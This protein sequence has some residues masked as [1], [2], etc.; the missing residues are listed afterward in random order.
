MASFL[1]C[2]S[3]SSWPQEKATAAHESGVVRQMPRTPGHSL[4]HNAGECR[5]FG[6]GA[7]AALLGH[8]AALSPSCKE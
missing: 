8:G 4:T 3:F 5:V 7:P 1:Q 6:A 2:R